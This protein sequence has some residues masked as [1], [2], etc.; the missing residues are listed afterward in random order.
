MRGI[1][2]RALAEDLGCGVVDIDRD[3]ADLMALARQVT[4]LLTVNDRHRAH[5]VLHELL[6]S[7]E[8]HWQREVDMLRLYGYP[9]AD[10]HARHHNDIQEDLAGLLSHRD[11]NDVAV[12]EDLVV[13]MMINDHRW[14]WWFLDSGIRPVVRS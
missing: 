10:E 3:H 1:I 7:A 14:K 11:A 12:C 13:R 8:A 5:T 9:G 4:K 6:S 2:D